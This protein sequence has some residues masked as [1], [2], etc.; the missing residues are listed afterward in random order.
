MLVAV[1]TLTLVQGVMA[2]HAVDLDADAAGLVKGVQAIA[3]PGTV[4]QI[5][6][7]GED[8][9]AIAVGRSGDTRR[10]LAAIA[11]LGRGRIVALAHSY[12]AMGAAK[13]LGT[14]TLLLNATR[15]LCKP[16]DGQGQTPLPARVGLLKCEL[17]AF[18]RERGVETVPIKGGATLEDELRSADVQAVISNTADLSADELIA[19]ESFIRRGGGFLCCACPW[20]W[21][22]VSKKDVQEMPLNRILEE[23]GLAFTDGT[24]DGRAGGGFDVAEVVPGAEFNATS[25]IAMLMEDEEAQRDAKSAKLKQAGATLQHVAGVLPEKDAKLRPTLESLLLGRR[26]RLVPTPERP[27]RANQ[28]LDRALLAMWVT[29]IERESKGAAMAHPSAASFPGAVPEDAPRVG[30]TVT[31]D[32]RIPD[33]HSTG[34]YAAPG[35]LIAVTV[36]GDAAPAN[37]ARR[38]GNGHLRVRIGCHKD[39][40]WHL[41]RW[42]RVPS[43]TSNW[44]MDD[45][46]IIVSSA[47]GG[48]IYIEVPDRIDAMQVSLRI[49]G[50][51]EAPLFVLGETTNAQ[52][53][54]EIRDRSAPWAELASDRLILTVPTEVARK[55]DDPQML[56]E[57][58]VK[59]LD[60]DADLATISRERRRPERFVADV[61]ISAGY[62]HSGYPIMTHLDAAAFMT[63]LNQLKQHGWGPYHELGHNHQQGDWTFAGTGEVTCNLFSLY[64]LETVCG[65]SVDQ[66]DRV[67]NAKSFEKMRQHLETDGKWDR[68]KSDPFLALQMY[69]LMQRE[70]GWDAFKRVF[71]E[72]R[73][74]LRE[75]RPK[76]DD[77]KR[78]Q[79]LTRFSKTVGR[80]LGPY[81]EAW[82]VPTS[83]EARAS[84]SELPAWMPKE[85]SK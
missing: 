67:L 66:S 69:A 63:E 16:L 74:L 36:M 23:A 48:L 40:L 28:S 82:G 77:Q 6:V 29:E 76:N 24:V 53:T 37:N 62:M 61:Q 80:N 26:D 49:E 11:T 33:W 84:I 25:A 38:G 32:T 52:W 46:E 70:F 35:E 47:F 17:E 2:S 73:N 43:I 42:Q 78:D 31:I 19:L 34:L 59:V 1:V 20:G 55:I 10:P 27:M 83:S 71:A 75:Q 56:M 57:H 51:V 3:E 5:A 8:A 14:G 18:Y 85:M 58:W 22:Q 30:K 79:W 68:W 54:G 81:F 50:A 9:R 21:A 60:A 45:K 15:W 65:V 72:Y 7:W 13:E 39:Q 12:A 4:G 44:S 64:V 41:D